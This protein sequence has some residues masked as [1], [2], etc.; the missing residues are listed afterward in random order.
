[1]TLDAI[2]NMYLGSDDRGGMNDGF[3][4]ILFLPEL[5]IDR[6]TQLRGTDRAHTVYQPHLNRRMKKNH[7]VVAEMRNAQQWR[8]RRFRIDEAED[9]ATLQEQCADQ[10]LG[11]TASANDNHWPVPGVVRADYCRCSQ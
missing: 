11:V 3:E 8:Q 5:F 6:S 10:H 1:M 9:F 4:D 2:L 7:A